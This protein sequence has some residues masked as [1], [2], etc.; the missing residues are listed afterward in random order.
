MMQALQGQP[1]AEERLTLVK[2]PLDPVLGTYYI[3]LTPW[4]VGAGPDTLRE[5][6]SLQV[7]FKDNFKENSTGRREKKLSAL[8]FGGSRL[9]L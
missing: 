4:Q 8:V 2:K 5:I 6:I 3:L 7:S 9:L 1:W